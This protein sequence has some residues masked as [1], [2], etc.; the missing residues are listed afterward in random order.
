MEITDPVLIIVGPTAIGKTDLSIAVS[1]RFDCEVISIDSMQVYRQMN[2]GT[3]KITP[4]EQ[5][6]IKHH[7][8]DIVDPDEEYNAARF[9]DDAIEAIKDIHRKGRIPLLTGG[10]GLYLHSLKNGLFHD[11]PSDKTTRDSLSLRIKE[12][13]NAA[14]YNELLILDEETALKLH[15]NDTSRIIRALEVLITTGE[16]L[17]THIK[18]Q[19]LQKPSHLFNKIMTVGLTCNREELYERINQRTLLMINKGL[20]QEVKSLLEKGYSSSLKSMQSIG[21]RHMLNFLRGEWSKDELEH[22]LA[23]DTRHYA[24]RQFTWFK[25]DSSI[26]WFDSKNNKEI[27]EAIE[28]WL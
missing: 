21:Y 7:L 27:I 28:N 19:Q 15:Q 5:Q 11:V 12:E 18:R 25:K 9:V 14:L 1:K 24:K 16:T 3:A 10:T 4:A 20:E 2:I 6:G 17:S 13:G 22:Y 26:E 8:I 23:R